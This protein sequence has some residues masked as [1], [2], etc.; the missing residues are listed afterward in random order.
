MDIKVKG[1]QV[2]SGEIYPSGSKN[3]AVALI[4]ATLLF[5]EP[6]SLKNIP[7]ITDVHR[8]VKILEKLGSKIKWNK[9][10]KTMI[11][12]NSKVNLESLDQED[13]GNMKGTSLLWGSM[14][15]RF[16]KVVFEDLPGGCTLGMRPL[17]AHYKAFRDLGVVVSETESSVRMDA[18]S[19]EAK[20]IWLLEM[21]VTATE[22]VIMLSTSLPGKTRIINAASEPQV[23]DLCEFLVK[24]GAKIKGIGSNILEIEGETKLSTTEHTLWS[25]HYEI[26]TFWALAAVTGGEITVHNSLPGKI[27]NIV[28][29]FEKFGIQIDYDGD[30]SIV[31]ANQTILPNGGN[32]F[33]TAEIKCHPWP[34]L[35]VDT[36]PLFIP[37]ALAGGHGQIIFHNWMYGQVFF[38]PA[39]L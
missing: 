37:M 8:L 36:L 24:S 5:D 23:Q 28:N 10:E 17:D 32:G 21:S 3:S 15:A 31:R 14:L 29:V 33:N 13:L 27:N 25:D 22:N 39:S 38:G 1:G 26:T 4:P 30:K 11:L 16:G 19:A 34:G 9:K 7:D 6:V 2:L 20:E 12:D 35:P 18:S